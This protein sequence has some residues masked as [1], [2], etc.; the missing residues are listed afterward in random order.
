VAREMIEHVGP[1][2]ATG[3]TVLLQPHVRTTAELVNAALGTA[4][5]LH[6]AHP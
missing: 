1:V 4:G 6:E 2:G 5:G 3:D